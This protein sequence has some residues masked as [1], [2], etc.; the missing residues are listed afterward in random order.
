MQP[1]LAGASSSG[2]NIFSR[3]GPPI[4]SSSLAT[5]MRFH[6]TELFDIKGRFIS[7]TT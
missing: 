2:V 4:R 7:N 1:I 6:E 3:R 5:P